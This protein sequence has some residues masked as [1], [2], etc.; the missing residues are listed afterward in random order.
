MPNSL[1]IGF[2]YSDMNLDG[3]QLVNAPRVSFPAGA[4]NQTTGFNWIPA[5]S[6]PPTGSPA[7]P[8][9]GNVPLYY[10]LTN[11]RLYVHNGTTWRYATTV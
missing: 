9:T 5:A 3:T 8:P 1:P 11:N 6:G 2:A 7:S 4:T 10:D